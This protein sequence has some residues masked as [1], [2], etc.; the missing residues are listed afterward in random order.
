MA[1]LPV[2]QIDLMQVVIVVLASIVSFFLVRT[3][4]N[5]DRNLTNL[6]ERY[7]DHE[8]RL[9]TIEGEHKIAVG[10]HSKEAP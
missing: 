7:D 6:W 4:R 10:R 3:L 9:S 2:Q 1:P 8:K 5:V